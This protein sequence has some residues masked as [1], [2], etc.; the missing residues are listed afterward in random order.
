MGI[1]LL[2]DATKAFGH[3]F[4][5]IYIILGNQYIQTTSSFNFGEYLG[6]V[7]PCL[8]FIAIFIAG[9]V[10]VTNRIAKSEN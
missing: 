7:W 9:S 8:L 1:D 10:F 5:N 6:I 2:P 3:I 4:P